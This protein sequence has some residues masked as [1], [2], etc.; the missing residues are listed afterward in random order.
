MTNPASRPKTK[1]TLRI[2][3]VV[4]V[5]ALV[6][7]V[8]VRHLASFTE[9]VDVVK[10]MRP[11]LVAA[12]TSILLLNFVLAVVRWKLILHALSYRVSFLRCAHAVL[13]V[14]PL[15]V[16]IPGR[17]G[18]ILRASAISDEVPFYEGVGSVITEKAIDVQSLCFLSIVGCLAHGLQQW[19]LLPLAVLVAEWLVILLLLKFRPT[20]FRWRF[21]QGVADKVGLMVRPVGALARHGGLLAGVLASSLLSWLLASCIVHLLMLAANGNVGFGLTVALW[22]LAVFAGMLPLTVAG[23]GTRDAAFVFALRAVSPVPVAEEAVLAATLGFSL[24]ATWILVFVGLPF[25]LRFAY[26]HLYDCGTEVRGHDS[27]RHLPK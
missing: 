3:P 25:G 20:G 2:V 12:A 16:V 13:A 17:A 26:R 21:V 15:A 6:L 14:W 19:A 9:L 8:L 23:M 11:Q 10:A 18:D 5:T 22:P 1:L 24:V 4:L 27:H 7:W